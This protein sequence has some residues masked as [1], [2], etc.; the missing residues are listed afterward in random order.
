MKNSS[1]CG[2]PELQRVGTGAI[3]MAQWLI[4]FVLAEDLGSIPS[5]D[6]V[7]PNHL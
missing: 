6:T 7:A 3:K 4:V 1:P 5:T 2:E